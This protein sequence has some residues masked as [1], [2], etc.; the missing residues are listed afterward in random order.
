MK[1]GK[2]NGFFFLLHFGLAGAQMKSH[3]MEKEEE[4]ISCLGVL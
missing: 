4:Y 3:K 1:L 2:T